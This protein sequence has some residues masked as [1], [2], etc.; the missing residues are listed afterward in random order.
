MGPLGNR[1]LLKSALENLGNLL[2]VIEPLLSQVIGTIPIVNNMGVSS[3]GCQ[4]RSK[5]ILSFRRNY[6]ISMMSYSHGTWIPFVF[7][8]RLILA[9]FYPSISYTPL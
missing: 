5:I 4:V 9:W 1:D 8:W 6:L 3:C 2:R 7:P